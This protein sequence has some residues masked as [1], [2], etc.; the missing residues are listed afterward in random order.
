[1]KWSLP[2]KFTVFSFIITLSGMLGIAWQ[3]F[4][5]AD[6]LLQREAVDGLSARMN[7]ALETLENQ[8]GMIKKDVAFLAQSNQMRAIAH[9]L[10]NHHADAIDNI[11]LKPVASLF[12]TFLN[13]RQMYYQIRLIGVADGGRE[14]VRVVHVQQN[15]RTIDKKNLMQKGKRDYFQSSISLKPGEI[16]FSDITL[17]R[18]H[19][20]I[21]LPPQPM[22]RVSTAL[23]DADGRV[24]AILL[25]NVDF[26]VFTASLQSRK[27]GGDFFVVNRH[28]D[29]L[30][31]PD[32]DKAMAFEYRRQARVQQDYTLDRKYLRRRFILDDAQISQYIFTVKDEALLI[33][34]LHFDHVHL[35]RFLRVGASIGLQTLGEKSAGLLNEMFWDT[36]FLAFF[37]ALITYLL[38]RHFTRPVRLMIEAAIRISQDEK[39]VQIPS[40]SGDE[41]GQLGGALKKM[42]L[43]LEQSRQQ[44]E[45]LNMDLEHQVALR[46]VE[47]S[48]IAVTL[49]SQKETLEKAL[50]DAEQATIAKSHFLSTMSHEIRTPL[51]GVLGLTEL[52]LSTELTPAQRE[53]MLTVQSSGEALL[54]ILNDILDFSKMEAGL[55]EIKP[56]EFNPNTIIE[57]VAKMFSAKVNQDEAKLE[58]IASG[59]AHLPKLLIG[60]ADRLQQVMLNLLSNAIKFTEE[61]EIVIA[62]QILSESDDQ[63]RVRFQVRDSGRGISEKDQARLFEEFTQADGTDTRKHGGTGLGL[64]I[65]KQLVTLMGGEIHL[66]SE[67][68]R[69]SCFSFELNLQKGEAIADGPHAY[70]QQFSAWR[71][72]VVD[73]NVHNREILSDMLKAWGS[74]CDAFSCA[75]SALQALRSEAENDSPYD[76]IL[77]D[78]QM[79]GMDGMELARV[80]KDSPELRDLKVVMTTTLDM[81]FDAHLRDQYGLHGFVRKPVYVHSLFATVLSVMGVR[82]RETSQTHAIQIVRRDERILLAEDHAVN[83]QVAL[84]LLANQGVMDVDI[85]HHGAEAVKLAAQNT[86]DL[87]FMDV[88]MPELDGIAATREIRALELSSDS[89]VHVPIIALTAHALEEDRQRTREAG[90]DDHLGKPLSGKSLRH[91]LARWLPTDDS[92]IQIE[93]TDAPTNIESETQSEKR[94]EVVEGAVINETVLRQLRSDM[95]FGIGMILDTYL[96]ELPK[97]IDVFEASIADADGDAL[98]RCGHKLKG[99][100]RSVAAGPLGEICYQFELLGEKGDFVAAKAMLQD[101]KQMVV[102]VEKALSADWVFEIR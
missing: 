90:M 70:R 59:I 87:I 29:Y 49:E 53:N 72:L 37:L 71:L 16:L 96:G 63:A 21:T 12:N 17:N 57:H 98:R 92:D 54:A 9:G 73:D 50:L 22:L 81:S 69:G 3:A 10:K 75:V 24:C 39:N 44:T 43:H 95:G 27:G 1:M 19:G 28:G 35:N 56:V 83:R 34:R 84:G 85:A 4:S 55:M 14:M 62:A 101:L 41:I 102:R 23:F 66:Q 42:L 94:P 67:L 88:Q 6:K 26:N 64:A 18:E 99:A 25:I 2:V 30:I 82:E 89:G 8:A 65:V 46:T 31:H 47:L 97:Q 52:V 36:L 40:G 51:N 80:I 5:T 38:V 11:D 15:I 91:M 48:K 60:D 86:Y 45:A 68:G 32:A 78:Q 93:H 33:G 77:I 100:S 7:A 61:G 79:Q 20:K 74:D 13:Q 58:L 76:L